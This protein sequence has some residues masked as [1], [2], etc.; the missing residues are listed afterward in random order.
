MTAAVLSRDAA[1]HRLR[2]AQE[3]DLEIPRI[4]EPNRRSDCLSDIYDFLPTYFPSVFFQPFTDDRKEMVDAIKHAAKYGGD[5]SVAGPRA[6]GKT[7]SALFVALALSLDG[8]ISFP[9]ILSKSGP[10]AHR[11]LKN[12]KEG[13]R[14]SELFAADFPEIMFPIHSLGGWSSRARQQTVYGEYTW[15]E[16]GEECIIFPRIRSELLWEHGWDQV[17]SAASEQVIASLGIE[18]PV[19]GY[20]IRN[21]RPDLAILDDIDDRESAASEIQTA[22][23]EKI[24]EEDV[25][26]LAGPD[27]TVARVMLC[28]L[29][30]RTCVAATFTDKTK[31]PSWRGQR[32]KLLKEK[33][34]RADRWDEYI[35]LRQARAD[36]DPDARVAHKFYLEHR[37]EMDAGA[38]VTNE[39]RFD[40]RPLL[41]GT[42]SEV[43]ALQACYNLI[44]DRGWEHFNTEYQND[45]PENT[46]PIESGI[47]AKLVQRQVSGLKQ[48]EVPEGCTVLVHGVD[49]GKWR[50]HWVVRAFKPD[51]TG[52]TIDYGIQNVHGTKSGSEEG[53]DRAIRIEIL[54]RVKEFREKPYAQQFRDSLTLVD[55]GYRTEAVYAACQAAGLGVMPVMGFGKS[56]GCA[57]ISWE[58]IYKSSDDK[59]PICDGAFRTRKG[60]GDKFWLVCALADKWKAWEHDRWMT[61]QDKPGCM[62]LWGER[63]DGPRLSLDEREHGHYASHIVAEVE[64]EDTVKGSLVRKWK[65]KQTENHW[66]DASYY[67]DVAAAMK[68]IRVLVGVPEQPKKRQ[69]LAQMAE[70]ARGR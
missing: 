58:E 50:F 46:G 24:V 55:A 23:R 11:E 12:L 6:D 35:A 15:L 68:G 64:I 2:R 60:I 63:G 41:D 38:V 42:P 8:S 17:R 40:S 65:S 45:P 53:L 33:P 52:Y 70:K 26:G 54:R 7:R 49:V 34:T 59:K 9:M 51:G 36:D 30:N 13:M 39:F 43:S 62:W 28:T 3:R 47:T 32:H 4:L 10:R 21:R 22:T 5:Q 48:G 19:R 18:G 29:I 25:G 37:E 16:W 20:S 31:K 1:R 61:A 67:A 66:L 44:A 56:A 27:K 57:K 14:E 69:T